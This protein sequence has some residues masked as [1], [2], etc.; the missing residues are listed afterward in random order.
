MGLRRRTARGARAPASPPAP[1]SDHARSKPA[2][3]GRRKRGSSSLLRRLVY[4]SL[5]LGV[6]AVI[7]AAGVIAFAVSTLPPIQSL[8]VPKRPPT[9]EIVGTD[10]RTLVMRGEMSGSD[11]S[12]K[13]LPTYLPRALVAIED[14]RFFR[15]Y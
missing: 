14:R 2:A 13:E 5:V 6:W 1:P 4:W 9:V 15:H 11:V 7:A 3:G 8:E 12:I 10:G